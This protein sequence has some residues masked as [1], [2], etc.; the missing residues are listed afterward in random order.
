MGAVKG[1]RKV[2]GRQQ[3][4]APASCPNVH[5]GQATGPANPAPQP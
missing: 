5:L 3:V 1:P 2:G 4:G